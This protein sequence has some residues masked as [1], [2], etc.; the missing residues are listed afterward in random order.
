M[1]FY[2]PT[3]KP[4]TKSIVLDEKESHHL[5][6]VMRSKVG[7]SVEVL[8][9][10]GYHFYGKLIGFEQKQAIIQVVDSKYYEKSKF[11]INLIVSPP[12]SKD[13]LQ[14][15]LEKLTELGVSSIG[16]M[17]TA[18]SERGNWKIDKIEN[19]LISAIKQS[20]NTYLPKLSEFQSFQKAIDA[21]KGKNSFIAYTPKRSED[22]LPKNGLKENVYL[23]IGPEG[24]FKEEEI[25]YA[26]E[27]GVK[28]VGLGPTKLRTET[29]AIKGAIL[30]LENNF[31]MSS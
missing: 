20:G 12:K 18:H 10:E 9:G 29:A 8:N 14:F 4:D 24:G 22:R 2:E 13:R 26:E 25:R 3:A 15:M 19:Y 6:N 27:Q 16:L 31:L 17:K 23:Y 5:K 21:A 7:D 28:V 1:I 30:L 11:S